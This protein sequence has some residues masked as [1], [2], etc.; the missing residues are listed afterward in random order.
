[1]KP[2]L[3]GNNKMAS[4]QKLHNVHEVG[5]MQAV[6]LTNSRYV[7]VL[8]LCTCGVFVSYAIFAR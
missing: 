7:L 2:I 4:C 1:M 3:F 8:H 6:K 5:L